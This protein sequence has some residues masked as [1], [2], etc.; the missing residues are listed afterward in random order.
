MTGK[1]VGLC[2]AWEIFVDMS[3]YKLF[4][5]D[6][7]EVMN[8]IPDKKVDCIICDPPYEETR[9]KWDKQLDSF[10]LWGGIDRI[11]KDNSAIVFFGNEP[12]S[13]LLRTS[14]L[15]WYRYDW[16]WLKNN[17][18][19]FANANYRPMRKYEDIMIFS[20][21]NA[22]AGGKANA[23]VYHPQG[24]IKIN[25]KKKN[26]SKRQG[27]IAYQNNN[28]KEFNQML[29]DG[30]EYTQKYTNYPSNLLEADVETERFHP[31]QKP[32]ALLE[33]L[34]KTYTSENEIV[35]DLTMGSGSTGVA[36]MNLNRKFIGIELDEK[37]FNIAKERIE[38][39]EQEKKSEQ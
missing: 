6:C 19:G 32:I 30:T 14:K 13:S 27:L 28:L 7:L 24:V 16:K 2:L 36:C 11:I 1:I 17:C 21:A 12:F 3:R 8:K 37:Y 18:T 4:L 9:A 34:I 25:K 31:T 33:Y 20:K 35:L 39:A 38:K 15:E 5:G 29:Q 10:K 22:S 26:T 23:M